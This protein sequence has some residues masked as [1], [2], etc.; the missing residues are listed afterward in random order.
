VVEL[1]H[2]AHEPDRALLDEVGER[3]AVLV[4]LVA[5][6][7]VDD[8]AQVRLDHPVLGGEVAALDAAREPD[9][10]G[11][12]QERR[13]RDLGEEVLEA[14]VGLSVRGGG[15]HGRHTVAPSPKPKLRVASRPA[16]ACSTLIAS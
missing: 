7:D 15:R 3:E 16:Q 13:A 2:R 9:L 8:E 6:G 10:L 12:G 14:V 1:L 5:L 11:G 4:A